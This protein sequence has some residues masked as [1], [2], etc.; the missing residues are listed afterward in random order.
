MSYRRL[1]GDENE[2]FKRRVEAM[3][4]GLNPDQIT[5]THED[6]EPRAHK[7]GLQHIGAEGVTEVGT[8]VVTPAEWAEIC[9]RNDPET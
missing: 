4:P 8:L 5:N 3:W 6:G 9:A 2:E 1:D 7:R